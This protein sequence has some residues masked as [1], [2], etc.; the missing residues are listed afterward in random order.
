MKPY[1][2]L[3]F[4]GSDIDGKPHKLLKGFKRIFLKAGED[5]E[6]HITIAKH[7]LRLYD[8]QKGQ[9]VIPEEV[10]LYVG[11]NAEDAENICLKPVKR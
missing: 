8:K 11:K 5:K 10:T 7:A 3:V 2:S 9:M 6:C 4:A 1:V